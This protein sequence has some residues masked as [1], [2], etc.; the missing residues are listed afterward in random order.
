VRALRTAETLEADLEAFF[1]TAPAALGTGRWLPGGV[2]G[3]A[4]AGSTRTVDGRSCDGAGAAA[5]PF[6]GRRI[7][8]EYTAS[9]RRDCTYYLG[10]FEPEHARLSLGTILTARA[11]RHAIEADGARE[12]DF[13]RGD[14]PYKYTW[15]AQDR[16][17]HRVSMTR[18]GCAPG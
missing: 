2:S 18:S 10:G 15:G 14:E 6:D 7:K 17:N 16:F 8:A 4:A 13:L 12:F 3:A 5:H 9:S 1:E 11:I